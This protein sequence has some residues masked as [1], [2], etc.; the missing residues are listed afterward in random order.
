MATNICPKCQENFDSVKKFMFHLQT[1]DKKVDSKP[2]KSKYNNEKTEYNGIKYDSKLEASY[3]VH[4][5]MAK[6]HGLIGYWLRQVP[7]E[8]PGGVRYRVDFLVVGGPE[9]IRYV[10]VKGRE[11]DLFKLKKKQVESLYP[12]EIEIVK[13]GDF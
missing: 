10:D 13:K 4:L 3:A 6:K 2:K 1:C 9:G 12:V 5:D 11:T 7:F 8:L